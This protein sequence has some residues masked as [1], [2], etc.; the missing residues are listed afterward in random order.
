VPG[1]FR[2]KLIALG[3]G[4]LAV[5]IHGFFFGVVSAQTADLYV[6]PASGNYEAGKVFTVKVMSDSGSTDIN[7]AKFKLVFDRAM[8]SVES[9]SKDGSVFSL[10]PVDPPSP[11]KANSSG[12]IE[13]EGGSQN[14]LTGKSTILTLKLKAKKE[15]T[16]KITL[17]SGAAI[18]PSAGFTDILGDLKGGVYTIKA[19]TVKPVETT[20]V[21]NRPASN[22]P[23]PLAPE[24]SS[25]SQDDPLAWYNKSS[26]TYEWDI[27]YGITGVQT[28]FD[29]EPDTTPSTTYEPPIAELELTDLEEGEQFFHIRFGNK[30][31]WGESTH[32]SLKV[33][34]T[35][36]DEF[37]IEIIGGDEMMK[38]P[39]VDLGTTTDALSGLMG[40]RIVIDGGDPIEFSVEEYGDGSFKV[41]LQLAGFHTIVVEALD[42]AGNAAIASLD[43]ETKAPK[44]SAE[45][46]VVEQKDNTFLYII[47]LILVFFVAIL[48]A[49]IFFERRK[50][51]NEKEIIKREANEV[52]EKMAGVFAV[53]RDEIEEQVIALAT[54]PN[55]TE[56]ERQILEKMKEA[57]EISEELLDKEVEDVRKLVN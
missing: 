9:I 45:S 48:L 21:T 36:P 22:V 57:L 42:M 3:G 8:F 12:I 52:R 56:S 35:A 6:S 31:G 50:F 20:P 30:S 19:G 1:S 47:S 23:K 24:I 16:G 7:A 39:I 2:N 46:V 10:W 34:L 40:Y 41:P 13:V 28:S 37:S 5:V 33:D 51:D 44:V 55:M 43:F 38:E 11:S 32:R 26:I 4:I 27:L 29:Y 18:S 17:D 15:G 49:F 25:G 14:Q 53:L 54:K